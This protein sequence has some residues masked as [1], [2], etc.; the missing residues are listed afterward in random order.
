[1]VNFEKDGSSDGYTECDA[2]T[3]WHFTSEKADPLGDGTEVMKLVVTAPDDCTFYGFEATWTTTNDGNLFISSTRVGG[4]GG[5]SNAG[6]FEVVEL[7]DK[8]MTLKSFSN[9]YSF[10]R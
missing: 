9:V 2:Q 8:Q 6:Q 10:G 7:T 5:S 3:T 4:M 1:M